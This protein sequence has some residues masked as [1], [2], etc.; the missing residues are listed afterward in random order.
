MGAPSCATLATGWAGGVGRPLV[1][2]GVSRGAVVG[3]GTRSGA[4]SDTWPR[5]SNVSVPSEVMPMPTIFARS[6]RA[7]ASARHAG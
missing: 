4:M 6:K 3:S 2:G 1:A 5:G 7:R